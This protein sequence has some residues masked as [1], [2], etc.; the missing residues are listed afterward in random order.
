MLLVK[1]A[2]AFPATKVEVQSL[3]NDRIETSPSTPGPDIAV[4]RSSS[5]RWTRSTVV[6][7]EQRWAA[8]PQGHPL[9]QR[10]SVSVFE[11]ADDPLVLAHG[12]TT[13]LDLWPSDQ[14]PQTIVRC[15]TIDDWFVEISA[16]RGIGVTVD[17]IAL[18]QI[19]HDVHFVPI[20]DAP[21][22]DVF[23]ALRE[24][25]THPLARSLFD[26]ASNTESDPPRERT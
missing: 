21:H 19:E 13:S 10:T 20:H 22:I 24:P 18:H 17:P 23:I 3:D 8:M 1:W 12:G 11:L 15:R 7:T 9:C 25:T 5:D 4:T 26:I 6:A 14:Q 16:S 2:Q